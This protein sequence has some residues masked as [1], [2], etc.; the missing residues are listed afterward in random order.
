MS[1]SHRPLGS[2]RSRRIA[3]SIFAATSFAA[4]SVVGP[5]GIAQ[6]ES[7]AHSR[8][9]VVAP[10]GPGPLASVTRKL[11]GELRSAGFE[12]AESSPTT[13]SKKPVD[14]TSP[15]EGAFATVSLSRTPDAAADVWVVDRAGHKTE[16]RHL[17]RESTP[18][19]LAI[20][21]FELVRASLLELAMQ[22]GVEI[23]P[24]VARWIGPLPEAPRA[25]EASPPSDAPPATPP[26][27]ASKK[28]FGSLADGPATRPLDDARPWPMVEPTAGE[29]DGSVA[30]GPPAP[31]R[32]WLGVGGVVMASFGGLHAAFGPVVGVRYH[33]PVEWLD[34][35]ARVA[36]S[37]A[38]SE[39][40]ERLRPDHGGATVRHGQADLTVHFRAFAERSVFRPSIGAG[41]GAHLTDIDGRGDNG[42]RGYHG[43]VVSF[44]PSLSADLAVR[45][46]ER[47]HVLFAASSVFVLPEPTIIFDGTRVARMGSAT[48]FG[49][50]SVEVGL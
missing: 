33:T 15:E 14:E 35:D 26:R 45:F 29:P 22:P 28:V 42:F 48:M 2:A 46:H 21:A 9:V 40:T 38:S 19:V 50:A 3:A 34:V 31:R 41:I 6:A 7:E 8:I 16:V 12:V 25:P 49:T 30:K 44:T 39:I 10:S 1:R 23:P 18:D 11:V 47:V 32:F 37:V 24:D 17:D 20:H 43:D 5:E 13:H 4:L 27:A 36:A